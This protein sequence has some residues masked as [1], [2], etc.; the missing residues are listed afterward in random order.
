MSSLAGRQTLRNAA[1]V[2]PVAPSAAG[3]PF[4]GLAALPAATPLARPPRIGPRFFIV[5]RMIVPSIDGF[6]ACGGGGGGPL[7]TAALPAV[8]GGPLPLAPP[9]FFPNKAL[10]YSLLGCHPHT[11]APN[12]P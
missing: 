5:S 9:P 6:S 2:V 1:S 4:S 7:P 8:R 11:P 10:K 12:P 3:W